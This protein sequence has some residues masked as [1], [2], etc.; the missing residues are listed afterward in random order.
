MVLRSGCKTKLQLWCVD[1]DHVKPDFL[2]LYKAAVM[3]SII[4]RQMQVKTVHICLMYWPAFPV[5]APDDARLTAL[6]RA[7]ES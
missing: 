5:Y 4:P 3:W 1:A 6:T 2:E 7:R